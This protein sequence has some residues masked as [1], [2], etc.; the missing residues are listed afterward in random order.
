LDESVRFGEPSFGI[1]V[2]LRIERLVASHEGIELAPLVSAL[3]R[4]FPLGRCWSGR[5]R[6]ALAPSAPGDADLIQRRR[7]D[8]IAVPHGD[9]HNQYAA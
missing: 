5:M 7:L 8:L 3:T 1:G 9:A 2:G 6:H 4:T